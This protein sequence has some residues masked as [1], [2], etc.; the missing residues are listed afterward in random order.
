MNLQGAEAS[1]LYHTH[2]LR[3]RDDV[4][5][6]NGAGLFVNSGNP[7]YYTA[8]GTS[9]DV[10]KDVQVTLSLCCCYFFFRLQP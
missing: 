8:K 9:D 3:H 4:V 1:N 10:A 5:A 2:V 7:I 6:K